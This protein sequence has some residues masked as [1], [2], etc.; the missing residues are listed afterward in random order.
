MSLTIKSLISSLPEYRQVKALYYRAFP[1]YE[2][3]SWRRLLF[4]QLFRRADFLIFYDQNQLIGLSYIIHHHGIHYV[5][6]LAVNDQVR[7][8]G[9]GSRILNQ[10]KRCYAPDTLIL[11]IEQPD[12]A[13]ANNHQRL[14]RLHFYRRNGFSM[15]DRLTKTPAVTYQLLTTCQQIDHTKVD[16]MFAWFNGRTFN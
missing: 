13:A 9:Y 15:T 5:L 4:K 11:D 2:Q 16:N 1:K 6:Y 3:E 14:R 10:L 12:T 8:Q 7:S